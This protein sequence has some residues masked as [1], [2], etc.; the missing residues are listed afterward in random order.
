M[1]ELWK[2]VTENVV[3]VLEFLG[4]IALMFLAAVLIQKRRTKKG[5]LK[6]RCLPPV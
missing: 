3:F 1:S 2:N 4:V 6:N 5:A